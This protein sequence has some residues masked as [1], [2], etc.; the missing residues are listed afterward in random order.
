MYDA[1]IPLSP[2]T[3][4]PPVLLKEKKKYCKLDL[5]NCQDKPILSF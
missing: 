5:S 2:L 3:P 1:D 4:S